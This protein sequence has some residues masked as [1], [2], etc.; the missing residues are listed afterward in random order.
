M[1][2]TCSFTGADVTLLTPKRSVLMAHNR[3]P[4][5]FVAALSLVFLPDVAMAV[6]V[7][8]FKLKESSALAIYHEATGCV[9]TDVFVFASSSATHKDGSVPTRLASVVITRVD[10]CQGE[11]KMAATGDAEVIDFQVDPNLQTATLHAVIPVYDFEEDRFF[12][13]LVDLSWTS[14][15]EPVVDATTNVIQ[16]PAFTIRTQFQGKLRPAQATGSVREGATNFTPLP[17]PEGLIQ[18]V[19]LGEVTITRAE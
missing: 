1:K 12:D 13:A 14:I 8:H 18:S 2:L 9:T 5:F 15:G 11:T 4:S 17:W 10:T 16:D 3:L 19:K 7:A 6:E